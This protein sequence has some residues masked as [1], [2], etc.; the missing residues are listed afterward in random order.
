MKSTKLQNGFTVIEI[1]IVTGLLLFA[2]VV[3]FT[4]KNSVESAAR[5]EA[6]KTTINTLYHTLESVYYP[7][8]K[9]YPRT[10]SKDSLPT[11]N[12]DT[13]KDTNGVAI[14]EGESEYRY[15]PTGCSDDGACTG[16]ALRAILEREDDFV[17][18]NK[19]EN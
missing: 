1:L 18:K 8:H 6:R 4:Q 11:V 12:P 15:E 3:F 2:S 9:S 7:E 10:I 13:F 19:N 16:Y 14:G 17:K 5:D